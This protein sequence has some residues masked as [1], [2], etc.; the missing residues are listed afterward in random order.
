VPFMSLPLSANAWPHICVHD[1]CH[2]YRAHAAAVCSA[3]RTVAHGAERC[4]Q[5]QIG[6]V[7]SSPGRLHKNPFH[8]SNLWTV[9]TEYVSPGCHA[10][11]GNTPG[12]FTASG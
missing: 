1:A 11:E 2:V 5:I 6:N 3:S 10:G 4:P 8:H 9:V 12:L 7:A